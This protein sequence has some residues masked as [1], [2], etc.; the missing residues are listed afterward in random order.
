MCRMCFGGCA[1]CT[2]PKWFWICGMLRDYDV[3]RTGLFA[4]ATN[5]I[6]LCDTAGYKCDVFRS[7]KVNQNKLKIK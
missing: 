7:S 1:I 2:K 5:L 3:S 4:K 6:I